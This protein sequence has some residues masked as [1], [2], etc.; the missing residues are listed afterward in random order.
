M[1]AAE[2]VHGLV[3][4][5]SVV[6]QVLEET[7]SRL[8]RA[9]NSVR[10]DGLALIQMNESSDLHSRFRLSF[11]CSESFGQ[12]CPCFALSPVS[13]ASSFAC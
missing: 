7:V 12:F 11:C 5:C 6:S 4:A 3:N 2:A 13:H 9:I 1:V 8:R 10:V